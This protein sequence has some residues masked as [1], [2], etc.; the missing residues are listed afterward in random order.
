MGLVIFLVLPRTGEGNVLL[1]AVAQE[2]AIDE[3]HPVVGIDAQEWER[4]ML[5]QRHKGLKDSSLS[6]VEQGHAFAP[7]RGDVGEYQAVQVVTAGAWPAVGDE[8]DLDEAGLGLI[9]VSEG[10]DTD[11]FLEQ[12][13]WLGG[14]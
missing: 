5:A 4:E 3:L 14:A 7:T 1:L 13:A 2:V 8:I 10:T 6:A 9:P 11:A 12:S